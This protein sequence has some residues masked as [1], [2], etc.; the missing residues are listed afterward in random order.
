MNSDSSTFAAILRLYEDCPMCKEEMALPIYQIVESRLRFKSKEPRPS[1]DINT[2][3]RASVLFDER[4][5]WTAAP[6][7]AA[8]ALHTPIFPEGFTPLAIESRAAP[9]P[10]RSSNSTSH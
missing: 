9:V 5:L 4:R 1:T 6:G 10:S 8:F 2:V 3:L 7:G